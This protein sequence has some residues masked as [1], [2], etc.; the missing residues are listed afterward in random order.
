MD[1]STQL[2]SAAVGLSFAQLRFDRSRQDD[3][4]PN[5]ALES[6][7]EGL[8]ALEGLEETHDVRLFQAEART[9]ARAGFDVTVIALRDDTP[10]GTDGRLNSPSLSLVT[11]MPL[12]RTTR[13]PGSG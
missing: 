8:V 13:T 11:D 12:S 10:S 6:L 1:P 4:D 3:A 7:R 5:L 2:E 9:L